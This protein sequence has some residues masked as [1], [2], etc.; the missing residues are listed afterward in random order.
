MFQNWNSVKLQL[1]PVLKLE[2]KGTAWFDL[3]QF[4]P[5]ME[6][7]SFVSRNSTDVSVSIST[8]HQGAEIFY[9]IDGSEPTKES[10]L[11]T[12]IF[13]ISETSLVKAIAFIDY[14]RVG[15]ISRNFVVSHATGRYVEYRYKYSPKYKAGY[16]DGLVDGNLASPD[17]KDGKW[18][19]FEGDDFD[20]IVNLKEVKNISSISF[21]FLSNRLS[22]IFLPQEVKVLWSENGVDYTPLKYKGT[23]EE[24]M[25]AEPYIKKFVYDDVGVKARYVRIVA[26]NIGTCPP[27]HM[28]EGGKAWLFIDEI[29][30][31]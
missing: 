11:F 16:D 28:G 8:I 7:K 3:L 25:D 26:K 4:F 24:N 27:G 13:K 21:R 17:F 14:A 31:E 2:G 20:V 5:D 12:G 1:S 22:W 23:S 18:Q 10:K 9:T 30:I 15:Y 6:M 19:G 29:I